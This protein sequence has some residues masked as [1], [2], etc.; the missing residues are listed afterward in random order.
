MRYNLYDIIISCRSYP[1]LSFSHYVWWNGNDYNERALMSKV[2]LNYFCRKKIQVLELERIR[3]H[4]HI[5]NYFFNRTHLTRQIFFWFISFAKLNINL[6]KNVNSVWSNGTVH[7]N[8]DK[9]ELICVWHTDVCLSRKAKTILLFL[10]DNI[11]IPYLNIFI[12]I[13]SI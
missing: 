4:I 8:L 6:E 1:P 11:F 13:H 3:I 9:F 12:S 7:T 10:Y 2:L 5:L